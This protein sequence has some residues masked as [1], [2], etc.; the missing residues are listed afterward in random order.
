MITSFTASPASV[1]AGVATNVSFSW[2]YASDPL[3]APTCSIDQG[4]GLVA[5][6]A[7]QPITLTNATRYQ[8]TCTS[9]AGAASAATT[10]AVTA[11]PV[12]PR[13]TSFAV[14]PGAVVS[15]APT[16]VTFS[17]AYDGVP[18]STTTCTID[19]GVGTV[20][21]GA[22]TSVTL[23]ADTL[24]TL[25]CSSADGNGNA[26]ATLAVRPLVAPTI[27]TV[28][29]TPDTVLTG[30]GTNVTWS[31]SYTTTPVPDPTCTIDHGVGAMTSGGS[32]TVNLTADTA[33]TVSCT[34]SAGSGSLAKTI[35]VAATPVAPVLATLRALPGSVVQ[36]EATYVKF[37]WTYTGTPVPTP[38][39]TLD[40]GFGPAGAVK[41]LTL[42]GDTTYQLT[43]TSTAGTDTRSTTVTVIPAT[44][45]VISGFTASPSR[46][47]MGTRDVTFTWGF[48]NSPRP[49][50]ACSIDHGVGTVTPGQTVRLSFTAD[51]TFTLTCGNVGGDDTQQ[52]TVGAYSFA[53]AV[54]AGY[55]HTC[56]LLSHGAVMCW[57][58]NG[59]G[60][61]GDGTFS[62]EL[63]PVLVH[64]LT[65][66][67]AI[68][69]GGYHSCALTRSGGTKCWGFNGSGQ[70][71]S[72]GAP[73]Y[74][75]P[76]DVAGIA[77]AVALVAGDFHTCAVLDDGSTMCWGA[78]FYGQLG[79]GTYNDTGTSL[80]V[81]VPANSAVGV[82]AGYAHT[83]VI[84]ASG[85]V[86]CWGYNGYGQLGDGDQNDATAPVEVSGLRDAVTGLTAGE[87]HT[88]A[89]LADA[90]VQCWGLD[91]T[92]AFG[93]YGSVLAPGDVPG[94]T[95]V[96]AVRS[97][98]YSTCAR[99]T[100]GTITCFGSNDDGQLGD[101]TVD[102][103]G[104][105]LDVAGLTSPATDLAVGEDFACAVQGDGHVR[106]WGG[107]RYGQIGDGTRSVYDTPV[108]VQ[109]LSGPASLVS[110][111]YGFSCAALS[112]GVEC[113]GGTSP[114][115]LGAGGHQVVSPPVAVSDA[116]AVAVDMRST[117][118]DTCV[119]DA[120]GSLTCWGSN[121]ARSATPLAMPGLGPGITS[122]ALGLQHACMVIGGAV[123]CAGLNSEGEVGT[124]DTVTV[125]HPDS[126][127]GRVVFDPVEVAGLRSGVLAAG[128][129]YYHSCASLAAG[130]VQCWGYS[131]NNDL[132]TSTAGNVQTTP[133][134]VDGLTDVVTALAAG[135]E[136]TCALTQS[137]GMKCWGFGY[138]FGVYAGASGVTDVGGL[139]SGVAAIAVNSAGSCALL[140]T[141]ELRCTGYN[142]GSQLGLGT[143]GY[144]STPT[145]V[146]LPAAAVSVALYEDHGCAALASGDVY[147]WGQD[148]YG[149]VTGNYIIG[150]R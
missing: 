50:P 13:P 66:A 12:P 5:S 132:G 53:V 85:G 74:S 106:C 56:A 108:Q 70:V 126:R 39:C 51:T 79:D 69:V 95:S 36:G 101:G 110:T 113:W 38:T 87:Y 9:L 62:D 60:Q 54:A 42:N 111:G 10:V 75:E 137:G 1:T 3:P 91:G 46:V 115:Q 78:N 24:Y 127:L 105:P 149:Q 20:A 88:C 44:P 35:K 68:A 67:V 145:T 52:A 97:G 128:A 121:F 142:Y 73:G 134:S 83:C 144:F 72:G 18:T 112:G 14:N 27:A 119:V 103:R 131:S 19:H 76:V 92:N 4:V 130:G 90:T 16:T 80:P 63:A 55:E 40:N 65:D 146:S 11:A 139:T 43:C 47:E 41:A 25:A 49:A 124:G 150:P 7:A 118:A 82:A 135:Y 89:R 33:F 120:S 114:A 57:G 23:T 148:N 122:F 104:T 109:G 17:W 6:G 99:R 21:S 28:W 147:C 2:T 129:G 45:P 8:L 84:E 59:Y 100:D 30:T 71:G 32:S 116:P 29:A 26:T 22:S 31:W 140:Q 15:G 136:H 133:V 64:N 34:S 98:G 102:S 48:A 141:G 94:L 77:G 117:F 123:V 96:A 138:Y 93:S 143:Q 81:G 58:S 37:D 61:L 107:N 86:Q 125:Q